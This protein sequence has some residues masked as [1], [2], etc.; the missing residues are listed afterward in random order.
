[1]LSQRLDHIVRTGCGGGDIEYPIGLRSWQS[2]RVEIG[3][4]MDS[5]RRKICPGANPSLTRSDPCPLG[6]APALHPD[7]HVCVRAR[8]NPWVHN[9]FRWDSGEPF[10]F[11]EC[12]TAFIDSG[13]GGG[14]VTHRVAAGG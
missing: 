8:S 14:G 11:S 1:M 5:L 13:G 6:D 7:E 9:L 12:V 3:P 10:E 4:K 2:K